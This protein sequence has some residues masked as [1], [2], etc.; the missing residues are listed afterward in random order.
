MQNIGAFPLR[1]TDDINLK[2]DVFP[3][4]NWRIIMNYQW[5]S[6][7][8][9]MFFPPVSCHILAKRLMSGGL[10]M[11]WPGSAEGA[12]A[13]RAVSSHRSTT[14]AG[15]HPMVSPPEEKVKNHMVMA[16]AIFWT[17]SVLGV[18]FFPAGFGSR[19]ILRKKHVEQL[20]EPLWIHMADQNS[21]AFLQRPTMMPS[22][23][24]QILHTQ[25]TIN[26]YSSTSYPT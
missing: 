2:G 19:R 17:Q 9:E 11:E 3:C 14:A 5:I 25:K 12:A 22:H 26:V 7:N 18:V 4:F 20:W 21:L 8:L 10:T 6:P 1:K 16:G 15:G 24:W 13:V 23:S